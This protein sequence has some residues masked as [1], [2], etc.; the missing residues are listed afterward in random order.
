GAGKAD[1]FGFERLNGRPLDHNPSMRKVPKL[2]EPKRR[3]VSTVEV[4]KSILR[5]YLDGR[6]VCEWPTDY[7]EFTPNPT[8]WSP[9]DPLR[10]AVGSA[11]MRVVFN[12]IEVLELTEGGKIVR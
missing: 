5:G 10:L 8:D 12:R 2:L 1:L 11:R 3:R 9:R 6:L 4:R 7:H